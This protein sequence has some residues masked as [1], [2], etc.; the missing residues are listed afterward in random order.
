VRYARGG[1][2]GMNMSVRIARAATGRSGVAFCGYHGWHDWYLAANLGENDALNGHLLPGLEPKGV[3]RELKGTA[4]PFKYNDFASFEAALA[5]LGDNLACVVMEPM[6]SQLPKDDFLTKVAARCRAAGGVFIVDE[7]TSGLRFGH[8]GAM[9]RLGIDPDVVVYAKAMS[10]GFPFGAVIGREPIMAAA[11]GSFI[12]SSYWTD[13]V[14][15]AAALAVLEKVERLGVQQIIW[16]R[17][18]R[19]QNSLR[20][21]A[22]RHTACKLVVGG[23]P[24]IPTMVFD[25][26]PDTPLAQTLY[27][28]KMRERGFLVATYHYVMLAHDE[29][30]IEAM[31][32]AAEETMG[33]IAAIITRGTLA[34]ESRGHGGTTGMIAPG[35]AKAAAKFV[36]GIGVKMLPLPTLHHSWVCTPTGTGC[37]ATSVSAALAMAMSR[38]FPAMSGVMMGNKRAPA[39]LSSSMVSKLV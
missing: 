29:A 13:G 24:A 39:A 23:M 9:A 11:D 28:R 38:G 34:E 35:C 8:P 22:A 7:V 36:R 27:V 26:G 18:E 4:L 5:K 16:A 32:H 14:G 6:R 17:G 2:D 20:A 30:R 37:P 15:P 33:E 25:L 31:L 1:G 10:N 19:L 12:S 3:P 21:L